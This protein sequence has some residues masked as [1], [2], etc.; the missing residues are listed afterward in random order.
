DGL[1]LH[2]WVQANALPPLAPAV[3]LPDRPTE[4]GGAERLSDQGSPR[5]GAAGGANAPARAA[6]GAKQQRNMLATVLLSQG[7][8]MLCAGDESGRTQQ[9]DANAYDQDNARSWLAWELT[10][11]QQA[12]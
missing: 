1:T 2:D 3:L 5:D 7:V 6:L 10:P 4:A 12:L 11:E 8:P 9:G